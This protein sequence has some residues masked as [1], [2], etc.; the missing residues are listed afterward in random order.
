MGIEPQL[1]G[2]AL[3][4]AIHYIALGAPESL[5]STQQLQYKHFYTSLSQVIPCYSCRQHFQELLNTYPIDNYLGNKDT[6]FIWTVTVHNAVNK[7]LNKPEFSVIDAKNKWMQST[8][9]NVN[10]LSTNVKI[11]SSTN[12]Y[13]LLIKIIVVL[14]IFGGG[15]YIG[16]VLFT[17]EHKKR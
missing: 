11:I 14:L 9:N 1:F 3:W 2:P 12:T 16:K 13:N 10:N 6:L 5:D 17:M 4:G 7:S 8:N 15:I